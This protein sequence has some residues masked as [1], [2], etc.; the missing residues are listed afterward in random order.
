MF[1]CNNF[2]LKFSEFR[3]S[4]KFIKNFDYDFRRELTQHMISKG[5]IDEKYHLVTF[6]LDGTHCPI[7][8]KWYEDE[9]KMYSYKL[10]DS[11]YNILT[12]MLTN[13]FWCYLGKC[14]F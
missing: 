11:G 9:K 14:F 12:M 3:F 5:E 13:G 7:W 4:D 1:Y 2:I 10:K 6:G 8:Q